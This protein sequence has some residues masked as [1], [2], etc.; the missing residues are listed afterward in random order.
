[1]KI[2]LI[3]GVTSTLTTLDALKQHQFTNVTVYGYQPD[4]VSLV[5]GWVDLAGPAGAA[6]YRYQPFVKISQYATEIAREKF[7]LILA[8]GLSQ[9]LPDSIVESAALGCY[10][11]HPTLLPR[12][13]GR[14]PIAWLV[15][16][17]TAGA[18]SIF[19][20]QPNSDADS[21]DLAVQ[22]VFAIDPSN[23]N[24]A[25]VE[26]KVLNHLRLALNS[27]L[28]QVKQ[29]QWQLQQ[30]A[31]QLASE[32]GVRRPEDGYIDWLQPAEQ[33]SAQIRASVAPHPGAYVFING[34]A[35]KISL[36]TNKPI[37]KI[38]GVAGRVLKVERDCYLV[39]TGTSPLW[40][41]SE[42]PLKVGVQ[43]GT[44]TVYQYYT[45]LQRIEKIEMQ[46]KGIIA[47]E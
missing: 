11:F 3:G 47:N 33:V 14:A 18:A 24:A 45:L 15:L 4:N 6:D 10:G 26:Q 23:D 16:N 38:T 34:T 42:Q 17:E 20:I 35:F 12:G 39:Q 30:Q 43:L 36:V 19:K 25:S 40:I 28:P 41:Q 1:M 8:I 5:S 32:Y 46:L 22:S 44:V 2:A 7:D 21:G 27:W 37:P 9:L 29:Q 13:R 31:H